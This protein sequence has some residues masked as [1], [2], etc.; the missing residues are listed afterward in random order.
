MN[1]GVNIQHHTVQENPRHMTFAELVAAELARARRKHGPMHSAHE[2]Y[3]VLL[4]EVEELWADIKR[5]RVEPMLSE[6]V[7]VAAMYQRMAEDLR[8]LEQR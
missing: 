5:D 8:L 3:A 2:G 1:M 4:E 7:Q 6:L